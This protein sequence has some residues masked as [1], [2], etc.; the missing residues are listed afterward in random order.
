MA[1]ILITEDEILIALDLEQMLK[2]YGHEV[3]GIACDATQAHDIVNNCDPDLIFMDIN[4]RGHVDG[5]SL[6]EAI[7]KI[8]N[9]PIIFCSAYSN[10]SCVDKALS[11]STTKYITKPYSQDLIGGILRTVFL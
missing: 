4:L 1:R 6:A 8:S 9:V 11:I 2:N 7:R 5:I 10:R 3:V